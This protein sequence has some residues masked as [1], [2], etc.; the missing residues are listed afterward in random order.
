MDRSKPKRVNVNAY[1][2]YDSKSNRVTVV[3]FSTD[4]RKSK[5]V[6]EMDISVNMSKVKNISNHGTRQNDQDSSTV[7][8]KVFQVAPLLNSVHFGVFYTISLKYGIIRPF[9][10]IFHGFGRSVPDSTIAV[11]TRS[12]ELTYSIFNSLVRPVVLIWFF[13]VRK[14]IK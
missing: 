8:K 3:A 4:N 7:D 10:T 9:K 5:I 13:F 2:T 6:H 1:S 12:P 14:I 11:T